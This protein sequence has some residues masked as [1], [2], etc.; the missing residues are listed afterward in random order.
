[1]TVKSDLI[2]IDYKK[3]LDRVFTFIDDHLDCQ[4]SL[5]KVAQHAY[6]SPFHFHRI[7]K[8]ATG[9]TLNQYINRRRIEK[10]AADLLH[11]EPTVS[12]IAHKYGFSD[13]SSFSKSFKKYFGESPMAF[14]RENPHRHSKIRQ[15]KSKIGQEY[16]DLEKY[17]C[18][19]DE[20]NTWIQM[21]AHIEVKEVSAI[22]LAYISVVGPQNV[23]LAY[24]KLLQWAAPLGLM[25]D[26][27]KM[28]TVYHDSFKITEADKVRMSASMMLDRAVDVEGEIGLKS[29]EPGRCIV[30]RFEIG[31]DEFE[32]SWTGLFLWMN[33]NGYKNA[34]KD[35]FEVY[36]NNINEHPEK[37]ATVDFCIPIE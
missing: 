17:I 14:I 15:V 21:N 32:K 2:Q 34:E 16:P 29:I 13:V 33:E 11:K 6:F 24:A 23:P 36:H 20:L 30:A 25:N 4:L 27:T 5:K 22:D 1:V 26:Q 28:V 9:E 8:L 10:A 3:R 35:P 31:R 7:F 12:E 19:I 18:V 37:K